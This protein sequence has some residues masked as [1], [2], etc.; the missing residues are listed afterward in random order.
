MPPAIA[1]EEKL[2]AHPGDAAVYRIVIAFIATTIYY[3]D[4]LF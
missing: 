1:G 2:T 3:L 4:T